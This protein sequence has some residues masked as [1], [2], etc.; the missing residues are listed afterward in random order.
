MAIFDIVA[1]AVAVA[2]TSFIVAMVTS[3][4]YALVIANIGIVVNEDFISAVV[5]DIGNASVM[6]DRTKEKMERREGR[7]RDI[8]SYS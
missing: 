8:K 1:D 5:F 7:W 4:A 2:S 3:I 6:Q